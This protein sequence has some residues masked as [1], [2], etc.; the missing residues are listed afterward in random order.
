MVLPRILQGRPFG[1]VELAQIQSLLCQHPNWSR[2]KLSREL[3]SLWHWRSASGQLKD[4]AARTLLLKLD[5]QG[6]I[7]LPQ[8]RMASPTR[9]GR[10][11]PGP[12]ELGLNQ[13]PLECSL[14]RLL[15]LLIQEV[16]QLGPEGPRAQLE[17]CLTR[18]HYLGYRSRVGQNLQ[19]WVSSA[20]GRA[21]ACVV[22]GA[23]AW[24]CSARD[25][26]IGWNSTQRAQQLGRIT[27]NTR[28]LILPWI[29]VPHLASHIL[30]R[31]TRELRRHWRAKYRQPVDLLETFV[32]QQRFQGTCYR[33][34]NWICLG[35]T[36]GRGR[37]GAR[38][39]TLSTSIKQVYVYPLHPRFREQLN[40]LA[41]HE[42]N[43]STADPTA[44]DTELLS[45]SQTLP[46]R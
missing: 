32:D 13:T 36:K 16:S 28:F 42:T 26:W 40:P 14:K 33:A 45:D 31:V 20:Q 43:Q 2:Y 1:P 24:Q 46:G 30:G 23:A 15:P 44:L 41:D 10:S 12:S 25:Q 18:Y 17:Q 19:Y 11:D 29:R 5:Q 9:S 4:M 3:A 27:N 34:A 22:F 6:W 38:T 7:Q 35:Q 8:R 39:K 37:Q 21:L